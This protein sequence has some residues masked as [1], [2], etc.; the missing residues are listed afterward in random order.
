MGW[1]KK[2]RSLPAGLRLLPRAGR[3]IGG[4]RPVKTNGKGSEMEFTA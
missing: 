3:F 2:E 1:S 4:R